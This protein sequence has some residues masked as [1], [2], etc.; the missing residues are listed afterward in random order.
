M[1]L[2]LPAILGAFAGAASM[3]FAV[4]K[5]IPDWLPLLVISAAL[6]FV[7]MVIRGHNLNQAE[8]QADQAKKQAEKQ[9]KQAEDKSKLVDYHRALLHRA[10]EIQKMYFSEY[11]E[12]YPDAYGHSAFDPD[13]QRLLDGIQASLY[14]A[15]GDAFVAIFNDFAAFKKTPVSGFGDVAGMALDATAL[16][17]TQQEKHWR[18]VID[19]LNHHAV[20][21]M[22]II[23]QTSADSKSGNHNP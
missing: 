2:W 5:W 13:T 17:L 23:K 16:E 14:S 6:L 3:A 12:K 19:R 9:A 10:N 22:E 7:C 1:K 20:Q 18:L 15:F 8:K 4:L 11:E 21:L